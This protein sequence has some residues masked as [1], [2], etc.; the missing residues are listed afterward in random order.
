MIILDLTILKLLMKP[1]IVLKLLKHLN[2]LRFKS[3]GKSRKESSI[4]CL[5][6]LRRLYVRDIK[7]RKFFLDNGG[8]QI[9][10]EF[11]TSEDPDIILEILFNIEDLIIRDEEELA[12]NKGNFDS[13]SKIASVEIMD[14][15]I[16]VN[17]TK[18]L[19]DLYN[20]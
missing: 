3:N 18:M 14:D 19:Y 4:S 13:F 11:L 17:I 16:K 1:E 7:L 9:I 8:V 10:Y 15:L 12:L 20:V 5:E 2:Y 6:I